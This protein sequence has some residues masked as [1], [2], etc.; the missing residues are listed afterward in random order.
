[1]PH[2]DSSAPERTSPEEHFLSDL[3]SSAERFRGLLLQRLESEKSQWLFPEVEWCFY[4]LHTRR[5][6]GRYKKQLL[7]RSSELRSALGAPGDTELPRTRGRVA[8]G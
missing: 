5:I 4:S 1:M 6:N 7:P 8:R 2:L 3:L